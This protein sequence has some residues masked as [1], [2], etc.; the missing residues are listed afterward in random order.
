MDSSG[1]IG[2]RLLQGGS[3][4]GSSGE[5][6]FRLLIL[7]GPRKIIKARCKEKIKGEYLFD[8]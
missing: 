5:A 1:G 6:G 2:P 3:L 4:Y 8:A 7:D